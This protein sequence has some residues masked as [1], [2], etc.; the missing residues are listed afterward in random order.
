LFDLCDIV[1]LRARVGTGFAAGARVTRYLPDNVV[2]S[3][4]NRITQVHDVK[5]TVHEN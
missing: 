4:A 1:R 3:W 5:I 2:M